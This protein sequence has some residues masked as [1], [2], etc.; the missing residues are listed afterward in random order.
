MSVLGLESDL[1]GVDA[2]A[3]R[4]DVC[5]IGSGPSGQ[6]VARGLRGG[7]I[8]VLM[9]EAGDIR[10]TR[11]G[12]RFAAAATPSIGR[13]YPNA[14]NHVTIRVG[15]TSDRWGVELGPGD[16]NGE[17]VLGLRLSRLGA[18]DLADRPIVGARGWPIEVDDL[19]PY[20]RRAETWLGIDTLTSDG[21]VDD[22]E[23][24][25]TVVEMAYAADRTPVFAPDTDTY[26]LVF[27]C[28]VRTLIA[29]TDGRIV[30]AIAVDRAGRE[31]QI[32]A[33]EFV[34]ALGTVQ[35][36]RLLLDSPWSEAGTIANSSGLVGRGLSDHPQLIIGQLV[37]DRRG[38]AEALSPLAPTLHHAPTGPVLRWPN[39]ATSP[40]RAATAPVTRMAATLLAA[41][42]LPR[43][44]TLRNGVPRPYGGRTG[45]VAATAALNDAISARA[46][47][48]SHLRHIPTLLA[49]F[50]EVAVEAYAARSRRP[51]QPRPEE[52]RWGHLIGG[53]DLAGFHLFA[54]VEQL[55]NPDNRITLSSR[56]NQV[57][58]HLPLIDWR[59]SADDIHLAEQAADDIRRAIATYGV[60][61]IR[62]RRGRAAVRRITSHHASGTTR[63]SDCPTE[64][65]VD[66]HLRSHDHP[67]LY[68]AGSAVF[69]TIGHAT[70]T[71]TDIALGLRLGQRIRDR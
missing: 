23:E 2:S 19:L 52:P 12:R 22:D 35:T 49:G 65:V 45:A 61:D 55:P 59:W 16:G 67:N 41:H 43:T 14:G 71:L 18:V 37:L 54:V 10:P 6:A 53:P 57:G 24:G 62:P 36:T 3:L 7:S 58:A 15:G 31:H 32:H 60:G 5:I 38:D 8:D 48:P 39:L 50:D 70:P 4:A 33:D 63:M 13:Q 64:G 26:R 1:A 56:T 44:N 27:G 9:V 30:Q 28:P 51:R 34:L 29:G 68:I 25:P 40:T 20:Y 47:R 66:P 21:Q 11:W 46:I 69:N 17:Q 42:R